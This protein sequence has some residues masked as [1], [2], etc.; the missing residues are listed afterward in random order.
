MDCDWDHYDDCTINTI[1]GQDALAYLKNNARLVTGHSHDPYAP[2]NYL[3]ATQSFDSVK[4]IFTENP[5]DFALRMSVLKEPSVDCQLQCTHLTRPINLREEWITFP[6][7]E[8]TFEDVDLYVSNVCLPLPKTAPPA[9]S[10]IMPQ[11]RSVFKLIPNTLNLSPR[12]LLLAIST[13]DPNSISPAM[14]LPDLHVTKSVQQISAQGYS[15]PQSGFFDASMCVDLNNGNRGGPYQNN[16]LFEHPVA[17]TRNGSPF[18][19]SDKVNNIRILTDGLCG[20]ACDMSAYYFARRYNVSAYSI[21][22]AHGEDL[23]M[24]SFSG[25]GVV[26]LSQAQGWYKASNITWPMANL[27]HRVAVA[28]S[29]IEFYGEGRTMPLEYDAELYRPTYLDYT[30][31]NARSREALWKEKLQ[32]KKPDDKRVGHNDS[33]CI[34]AYSPCG[35]W[36]TSGSSEMTIRLWQLQ[37]DETE[38]WLCV[39]VVRGFSGDAHK[40]A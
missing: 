8:A 9:L 25:A 27:P 19:W 18:P 23:F 28:F 3:L 37:L 11:N 31:V 15:I 26:N 13:L 36:V 12:P 21:G 6:Q 33:I 7:T 16:D 32:S 4:G 24:F 22:G 17:I 38:N 39:T 29:W 35:I 1:N 34:L 2:L 30:T 10:K 14:P 40:T 20:S 5:D